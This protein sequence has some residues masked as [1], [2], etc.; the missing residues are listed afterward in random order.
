MCLGE[1]RSDV[2]WRVDD[3]KHWVGESAYGND[4]L[5]T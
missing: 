4:V 1:M 3:E 2:R 5:I